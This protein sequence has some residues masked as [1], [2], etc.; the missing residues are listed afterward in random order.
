MTAIPAI[1]TYLIAVDKRTTRRLRAE[2][3]E[4][5]DKIVAMEEREAAREKEFR[6]RDAARDKELREALQ[7]LACA[8][9]TLKAMQDAEAKRRRPR[10]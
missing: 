2:N 4:L 7:Q 5:A 10:P 3:K 9:G 8:N 1:I 6:E